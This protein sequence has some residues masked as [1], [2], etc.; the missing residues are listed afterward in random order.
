MKTLP[1]LAAVCVTALSIGSA[2]AQTFSPA[3]FTPAYNPIKPFGYGPVTQFMAAANKGTGDNQCHAISIALKCLS[4]SGG[5]SCSVNVPAGEIVSCGSA[6]KP[7]VD[8][9]RFNPVNCNGQAFGDGGKSG[10]LG[11]SDFCLQGGYMPNRTA[12]TIYQ[13]TDYVRVGI[14]RQFG[15]MIMELYGSDKLDRILQNPG[16][17]M[18]LSLWA[19]DPSYASPSYA[20]GFFEIPNPSVPNW[21]SKYN[22]TPYSTQAACQ[23]ANP[24]FNCAL[25][26]AGP[27]MTATA[28]AV[29]CG[30]NDRTAGSPLNPIQGQSL[31]CT[32][33][34][35]DAKVDTVWQPAPGQI[36]VMK[37]NPSNFTF[38]SAFNGLTWQQTTSVSGPAAIAT[39]HMVNNGNL[40]DTAFQEIPALFLHNGMNKYIYYYGGSS[41]YQN[42]Q[43]P[44]SRVA[45]GQSDSTYNWALQLPNRPG[46]FGVGATAQLQED[47]ISSCDSTETQ[48]FTIATFSS[49]SQDIIVNNDPNG[50]YLGVHGFFSLTNQLNRTVTVMV[51]PYRFDASFGGTTVRQMIYNLRNNEAYRQ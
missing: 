1:L 34:N 2:H 38:S 7:Q 8:E 18:Q 4:V 43:S 47:W 17:G 12:D 36:A 42:A 32:Y 31:G 33:G 24:G 26:V 20:R 16:G 21:L 45:V 40:P 30:A 39:Y 48:C 6:L 28:N 22:R 11:P 27:N 19:F 51:F 5:N 35:S 15:G 46:P 44:V 3:P 9:S 41:P 13:Y 49:S 10:L 37:S 25:G 14:N 50:P 23:G 29:A